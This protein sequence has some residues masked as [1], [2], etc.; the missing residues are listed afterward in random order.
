MG[1]RETSNPCSS[2]AI[3]GHGDRSLVTTQDTWGAKQREICPPLKKKHPRFAA[4]T[5]RAA[6]KRQRKGAERCARCSG[7]GRTSAGQGELWQGWFFFLGG[8]YPP[9]T[10]PAPHMTP[11][12]R[13]P[14]S[15][16]GQDPALQTLGF[17]QQTKFA[18]RANL[19]CFLAQIRFKR[20]CRSFFI[21]FY[22]FLKMGCGGFTLP[23][24]S[25]PLPGNLFCL[26]L[27]KRVQGV[28][29][30]PPGLLFPPKLSTFG[31]L[32]PTRGVPQQWE[33][34]VILI[35]GPG[36]P[37]TGGGH[38]T[39]PCV[40]PNTSGYTRSVTTQAAVLLS[41]QPAKGCSLNELLMS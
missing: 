29:R 13:H 34:E 30:A 26:F 25:L 32:S 24:A 4:V 1:Q 22:F 37:F 18:A 21:I 11:V 31:S 27:R 41:L 15:S 7:A 36:A 17:T 5:P 20:F 28:S 9:N 40:S 16:S 2:T 14:S 19:T 8:G 12:P 38:P 10:L 3:P 33:Q 6:P 35:W 39:L 23:R